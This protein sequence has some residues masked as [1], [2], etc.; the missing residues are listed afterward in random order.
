M[1]DPL[2]S[3]L[4]GWAFAFVLV[5]CRVSAAVM[6]LPGLGES[7]PPATVRA[8][9][10]I[11]IGVLVLP[12]AMASL[13]PEPSQPIELLSL[14]AG[15]L[16]RGGL[17]G[18]LA[19]LMALALPI[20]GQIAA[21]QIG[22]TSVIQP[23][24]ELGAQNSGTSRLLSL[25]APVM[26]LTSGLYALPLQALV[27]SYHAFP[28]G[29]PFSLGDAAQ[30][31]AQATSACFALALRLAAPLIVAGLGWQTLSGFLAR[32]VPSLQLFQVAMPGQL[33]G[34]LLIFGL[35][36]RQML[37]TWLDALAPALSSLPGR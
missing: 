2:L 29:G 18:W 6:L 23:D 22:L 21:V 17:L 8:G 9:L 37:Q 3:Q 34:G 11:G 7:A 16:L 15:E 5:L 33:L 26:I 35:L 19:R 24:P 1:T 13:P 27:G 12:G 14:I 30:G 31:V 25:A 28:P 10:A 4:P 20:A 36:L 32:L